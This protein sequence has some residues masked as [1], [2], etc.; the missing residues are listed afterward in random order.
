M[1]GIYDDGAWNGSARP[2][3]PPQGQ[4]DAIDAA[5][6]GNDGIYD[7]GGVYGPDGGPDVTD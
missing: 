6:P 3:F 2:D 1:A 5:Q 7:D 4:R